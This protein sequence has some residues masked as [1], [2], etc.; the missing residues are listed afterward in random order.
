M[1]NEKDSS[2][3]EEGNEDNAVNN[4]INV[5]DAN[6]ANRSQGC[7]AGLMILLLTLNK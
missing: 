7:Q 4:H 3:C 5:N 6:G 1:E 2:I